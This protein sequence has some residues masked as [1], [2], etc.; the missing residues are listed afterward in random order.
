MDEISLPA[1]IALAI[2]LAAAGYGL[3][4]YLRAPEAAS[5][6]TTEGRIS[7]AR[8][9]ERSERDSDGRPQTVYAPELLYE[10]RVGERTYVGRRIGHIPVA[11]SWR[12]YA[13]GIVARYSVDRP[14]LVYYDPAAPQEAVLEREGGA[15]VGLALFF[16]G[17][18]LAGAVVAWPY[19]RG[20]G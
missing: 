19:L 8:V 13:E 3:Y 5:W 17:L 10:Y 1:V 4:A 15:G 14:V 12:S 20:D 11:V 2:G 7:A 6:V 16:G 9:V 18:T